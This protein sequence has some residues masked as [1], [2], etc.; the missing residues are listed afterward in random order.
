MSLNETEHIPN[1][2]IEYC[3]YVKFMVNLNMWSAEVSIGLNIENM[4]S[5][6]FTKMLIIM[7]CHHIEE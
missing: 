3:L 6:L 1:A 4:V 7:V 5:G 2:A